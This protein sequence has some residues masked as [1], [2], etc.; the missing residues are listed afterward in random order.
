MSVKFNSKLRR[1]IGE[2]FFFCI[3]TTLTLKDDRIKLTYHHNKSKSEKESSQK[4]ILIINLYNIF[5]SQRKKSLRLPYWHNLNTMVTYTIWDKVWSSSSL[6]CLHS[7]S[8]HSPTPPFCNDHIDLMFLVTYI[9]WFAKETSAYVLL[10]I[11]E[12]V[13]GL[14][15]FFFFW[16]FWN[17]IV[18]ATFWTS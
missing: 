17:R 11:M 8:P 7:F 16:F 14:Y 5:G 15:R 1:T 2:L 13:I 9:L 10:I 4:K 12:Y 18:V 3:S 6:L